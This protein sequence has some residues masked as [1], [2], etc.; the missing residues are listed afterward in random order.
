VI[1]LPEKTASTEC[2]GPDRL[3]RRSGS[4]SVRAFT[5]HAARDSAL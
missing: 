1:W 4:P 3:Q 5:L 2:Q